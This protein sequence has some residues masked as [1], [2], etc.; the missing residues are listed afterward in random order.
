MTVKLPK[1]RNVD[2]IAVQYIVKILTGEPAKTGKRLRDLLDTNGLSQS[3]AARD[4]GISDR[5][6]RRYISGELELPRLAAWALAALLYIRT[7]PETKQ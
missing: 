2:R 1:R 4:L 5:T 7:S 3:G 6:M